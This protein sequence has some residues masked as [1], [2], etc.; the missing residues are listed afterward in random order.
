MESVEHVLNM[1][2]NIIR[3]FLHCKSMHE[4]ER[5]SV[6][7]ACSTAFKQLSAPGCNCFGSTLAISCYLLLS[8]AT[9]GLSETLTLLLITDDLLDHLSAC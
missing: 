6:F 2:D 8:L 3:A 9:A 7:K 5:E 4:R 1:F